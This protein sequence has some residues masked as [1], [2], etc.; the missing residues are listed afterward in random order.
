MASILPISDVFLVNIQYKLEECH[1]IKSTDYAKC[2]A[3]GKNTDGKLST[4]K[5]ISDLL[6]YISMYDNTIDDPIFISK[7]AEESTNYCGIY[8]QQLY[9]TPSTG[10]IDPILLEDLGL[11]YNENPIYYLQLE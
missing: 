7:L 5:R 9:D 6:F 11:I 2:L 4:L 10:V 1:R 8:M 3:L